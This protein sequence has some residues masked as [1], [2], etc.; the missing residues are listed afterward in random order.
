[1]SDYIAFGVYCRF[2]GK[3][4]VNEEY[5]KILVNNIRDSIIDCY[6]KYCKKNFHPKIVIEFT[7]KG[8]EMFKDRDRK[9][10]ESQLRKLEEN[11][12]FFKKVS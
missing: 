10:Q 6:C 9:K 8:F 5:D 2:C 7:P 12:R 1:M 11:I 3:L 4:F